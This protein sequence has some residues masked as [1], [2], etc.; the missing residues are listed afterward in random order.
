LQLYSKSNWL[1]ILILTHWRSAPL[2]IQC[3]IRHHSS[4]YT[5]S[6]PLSL[7]Q[8]FHLLLLLL[9]PCKTI[10]LGTVGNN[11]TSDT[12]AKN[13]TTPNVKFLYPSKNM[14]RTLPPLRSF[15]SILRLSLVVNYD[16]HNTL[17]SPFCLIHHWYA[18]VDLSLWIIKRHFVGDRIILGW[19]WKITY[20]LLCLCPNLTKESNPINIDYG[21]CDHP[22]THSST[23]YLAA[24]IAETNIPLPTPSYRQP[25]PNS[26]TGDNQEYTILIKNKIHTQALL[27]CLVSLNLLICFN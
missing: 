22:E 4:V 6:L 10:Q 26:H 17:P 20:S 21:F 27:L 5:E 13:F 19:D 15:V 23:P 1:P 8:L 7:Q 16:S 3:L 2:T 9:I 11:S 24:T 18:I 25:Q 12:N 14:F